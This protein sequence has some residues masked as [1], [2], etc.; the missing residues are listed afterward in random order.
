MTASVSPSHRFSTRN[1]CPICEGGH[2][3]PTGRGIRCYGFLSS[4][5]RY[6]HCAAGAR[7]QLAAHETGGTFAHRLDVPAAVATASTRGHP[8]SAHP[9]P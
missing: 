1:P 5:S 4:G 9:Q 2:D 8:C 7:R 3:L 6:A